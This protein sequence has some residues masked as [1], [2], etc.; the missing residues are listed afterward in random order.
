MDVSDLRRDLI[1]RGVRIV[2]VDGCGG[3]G[4]S[5]LA[6]QLAAGWPRAVVV[7]V[8]DFY[9]PNSERQLQPATHGGNVD[10][11]R[12]VTQVLDPASRGRGARY[13]RYDWDADHLAEW[14]EIDED[15]ILIVEGVY[16]SSDALRRYY[17]FVLW[18]ACPYDVRLKRGLQRDG[19]SMRAVWTEQWMPAEARYVEDERPHER[20]DIV[21]DGSED[22]LWGFEQRGG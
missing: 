16:S 1:A 14:N 17:E 20:A 12:L 15:S 9:R 7:E 11:E 8:D 19:E 2:A 18:V 4:K 5:L 22:N 21:L 6:S 13:Q 10:L 3:S